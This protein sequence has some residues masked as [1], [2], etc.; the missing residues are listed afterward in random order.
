MSLYFLTFFRGENDFNKY[1]TFPKC[2]HQSGYLSC[3]LEA[4]IYS[5]TSH[6]S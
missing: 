1:L 4:E 6:I 5:V 3:R 2:K